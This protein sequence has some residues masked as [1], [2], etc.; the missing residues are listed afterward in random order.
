MH[1]LRFMGIIAVQ[2]DDQIIRGG[3][4]RS[5][6]EAVSHGRA[7]PQICLVPQKLHRITPG[8]CLG[9]L[10]RAIGAAIVQNN[11]FIS[12]SALHKFKIKFLYQTRKRYLLVEGGQ[13]NKDHRLGEKNFGRRDYFGLRG[14]AELGV[15][16]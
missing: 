9:R 14:W 16:G 8:K 10:G 11:D 4:L 3:D 2:C 6:H 1:E 7:E 15:H 12:P 5:V 13:K